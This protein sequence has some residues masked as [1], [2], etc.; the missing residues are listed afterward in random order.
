VKDLPVGDLTNQIERLCIEYEMARAVLSSG[1][2]RTK[3][4]NGIMAQ[5][6]TI[7]PSVSFLLDEF[8]SSPSAGKRLAAIAIMQMEP[9]KAD[10]QWLAARFGSESPFLFYQAALALKALAR[11]SSGSDLGF[12]LDVAKH[13]ISR[14]ESFD[15]TPD[16]NTLRVLHSI[17][18]DYPKTD[19][20]SSSQTPPAAP[21]P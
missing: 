6:R 14:I 19:T 7:G 21:S 4:M 8:K 10:P 11:S 12:V 5:M 15:G 2:N 20:T 9:S 17:L 18:E 1:S 13:G 3:V 16:S